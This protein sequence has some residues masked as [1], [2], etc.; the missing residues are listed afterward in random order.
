M[1][2]NNPLSNMSQSAVDLIKEGYEDL[3]QPSFIE[4]G[5]I[6]S[7]LP[8]WIRNKLF[9]AEK[10]NLKAEYERKM[11][12]QSLDDRL[13]GKKEEELIE[14]NLCVL[15][16][17]LQAAAYTIGSNE[18]R[19]LYANLLANAMIKDRCNYVHPAF[20]EIIKQM[21]HVDA[22][23]LNELCKRT[24]DNLIPIVS[25]INNKK[26]DSI[27]PINY[28]LFAI[29]ITG[30]SI[31]SHDLQSSCI[32]NLCRLGIIRLPEYVSCS[33]EA[34]YNRILESDEYKECYQLLEKY[35]EARHL[36]YKIEP[37][38]KVIEFTDFGRLFCQIC[39]IDAGENS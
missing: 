17:A 5:K 8:R 13:K 10:W 30:L 15:I 33:D 12:E 25:I 28:Q 35:N 27:V 23:I 34:A 37:L 11:F 19:N 29:N 22:L 26:T 4:F 20:V 24:K 16:P 7:L 39:V 18:L 36:D 21:S 31:L 2:E 9:P 32:D 14:P 3:L 6:F 1:S 38:N